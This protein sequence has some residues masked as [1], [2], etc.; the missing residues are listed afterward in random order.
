MQAGLPTVL[1]SDAPFQKSKRGERLRRS[2]LVIGVCRMCM[3]A[4]RMSKPMEIAREGQRKK[5]GQKKI[6]H[7]LIIKQWT[8]E[9]A[10]DIENT[11]ST[12]LPCR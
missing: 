1:T 5:L 12:I 4:C 7:I 9:E 3:E 8:A 10:T 2:V 6:L 11:F